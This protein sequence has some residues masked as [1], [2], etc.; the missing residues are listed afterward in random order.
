MCPIWGKVAFMAG[1]RLA[2]GKKEYKVRW[3]GYGEKHD[4]WEPM[5]NLSN[6]VQE[7]AA[8]DLAKEK[9]NLLSSWN[10]AVWMLSSEVV[11][12]AASDSP[13]GEQKLRLAAASAQGAA[14][15][16]DV[17]ARQSICAEQESRHEVLSTQ[18]PRPTKSSNAPWLLLRPAVSPTGVLLTL[19]LVGARHYSPLL[20]VPLREG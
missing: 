11:V 7:M 2:G 8:F 12:R 13:A 17:R 1:S 5:E 9:A 14:R 18:V 16:R 19:L 4:S 20:L 3:E 10:C 15:A 6:L